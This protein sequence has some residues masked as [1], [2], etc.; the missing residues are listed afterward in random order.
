[1]RVLLSSS[2]WVGVAG[3]ELVPFPGTAPTLRGLRISLL[4]TLAPSGA[5]LHCYCFHPNLLSFS[6]SN[7]SFSVNHDQSP[8]C[9]KEVNIYW[10]TILRLK[11]K[12]WKGNESKAN[13]LLCNREAMNLRTVFL[14]ICNYWAFASKPVSSV[15]RYMVIRDIVIHQFNSQN[16]VSDLLTYVSEGIFCLQL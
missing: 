16:W 7:A 12:K 14:I 3:A 4:H 13:V 10:I 2:P 8:I 1:M 15:N 11:W 9:S 6:R 5:F